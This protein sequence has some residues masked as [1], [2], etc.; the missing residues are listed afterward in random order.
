MQYHCRFAGILTPAQSEVLKTLYD[1]YAQ[2]GG[3]HY[4]KP[5][6]L[7][8]FRSS[9]HAITLRRLQERGFVEKK[10]DSPKSFSYKITDDGV[11][12]WQAFLES[13]KVP[14]HATPKNSTIRQRLAVMSK[15]ANG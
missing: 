12:A 5:K 11:Q 2:L 4:W 8:A 15:L 1:L 3:N 7:G 9:H 6:D 13:A 10:Q 14:E